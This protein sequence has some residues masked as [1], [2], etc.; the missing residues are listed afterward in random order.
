MAKDFI[1]SLLPFII[2][3]TVLFFLWGLFQMV[4]ASDGEAREEAKGY[5]I[6]AII[7]LF[8][9]VSV[10]GLVNVLVRS[11]RLD[12]SAPPLPTVRDVI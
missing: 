3:L 11:F 6:W 4:R 10:W 12:N 8:V 5:V 7:A 9:M 2:S 1:N